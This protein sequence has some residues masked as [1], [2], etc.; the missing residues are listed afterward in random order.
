LR[1]VDDSDV[2]CTTALGVLHS[3]TTGAAG[4]PLLAGRS[5]WHAVVE[6]DIAVELN[7]DLNFSD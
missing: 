1:W 3:G 6:F 5:T 7:S 2:L 4:G